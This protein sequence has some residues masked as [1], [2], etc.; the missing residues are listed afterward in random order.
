MTSSNRMIDS[1]PRIHVVTVAWNE[2]AFL[3]HFLRHYSEMG[4]VITVFDNESTDRTVEIAASWPRTTV[5][6]FSTG[7]TLRDAVNS[8]IKSQAW[9]LHNSRSAEW[10][11]CVDV[12]E[13]I[14]HP[15]LSEYLRV[16]DYEGY[17]VVV[18]AGV[19]MVPM[20][21]E[22]DGASATGRPPRLS[23]DGM[24]NALY[25][26]PVIFSARRIESVSFGPG[27]HTAKFS[28]KPR[29]IGHRVGIPRP[30]PPFPASMYLQGLPPDE[31]DPL[32]LHYRF[33]DTNIV[34]RW[35]EREWR[36]SKVN[37]ELGMGAHY[38]VDVTV[39]QDYL[40]WIATHAT[41]HV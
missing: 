31:N 12:D 35:R 40:Q 18:P 9:R 34:D 2:E 13:L 24:P 22:E 39:L 26:K 19:D 8:Y 10:V 36:R 7:N 37:R 14:Y 28:P 33:Y 1:L 41:V 11:I 5:Q 16:C 27:A 20:I 6:S 23:T 4:A 32:L 38:G 3:P 21:M 17:D 30:R 29:V 15:N 25:N